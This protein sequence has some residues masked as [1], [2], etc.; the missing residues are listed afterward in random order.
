MSRRTI[1]SPCRRYRYTLWREWSTSDLFDGCND[2]ERGA[3]KM[4][5]YVQ[6]IGLN[7]S[8]ADE[9]QDDP[10]VRRCIDFAKRWGFGSLCMTNA[11]AFRATDPDVMMAEPHPIAPP[12]ETRK[13]FLGVVNLNDYWISEVAGRATL[14]VAAWGKDGAHLYR[15]QKVKLLFDGLA[16]RLHCL[17]TN[18][19]GTPKHPLYLRAD[20]QPVPYPMSIFSDSDEGAKMNTP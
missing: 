9:V 4:E 2:G 17:G 3:S 20:L 10:T 18:G 5:Q 19:N 14:I 7:P 11:F 1:F 13:T 16:L 6:F 15:G 12:A 8:T